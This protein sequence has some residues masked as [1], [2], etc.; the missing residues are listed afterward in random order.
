MKQ[1]KHDVVVAHSVEEVWRVWIKNF[2]ASL[3]LIVP[4]HY[5]SIDYLDGP[6]LAPGGVFLIKYNPA[7]FPHFDYIKAKVAILDN[8][9]TLVTFHTPANWSQGP[10]PTHASQSGPFNLMRLLSMTFTIH[11]ALKQ[12]VL[13]TNNETKDLYLQLTRIKDMEFSSK[14]DDM[15]GVLNDD[16]VLNDLYDDQLSQI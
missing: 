11:D 14:L 10:N 8:T 16:V 1:V 4:Q 12:V 6:P 9:L 13:E 7:S 15:E 2:Q 3:P 5:S